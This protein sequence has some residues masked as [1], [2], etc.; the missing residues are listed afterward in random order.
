MAHISVNGPASGIDLGAAVKLTIQSVCRYDLKKKRIIGVEWKQKDEREQGPAS[1]AAAVETTTTLTRHLLDDEPVELTEY[2]LADADVDA[3]PAP[4]TEEMLQLSYTDPKDRFTLVY[5]REWQIVAQTDEHLTMRLMERGDFVA[6]VT[7]TPWDKAAPG[8]HMSGAELQE[9]MDNLPDWTP[10]QK[11]EDGE[12]PADQKD[13]WMYRISALGDLEGLKVMENY[14]VVAGPQ[15]DQ[16]ILAFTLRQGVVD[17]LG[18]RDM[19]LA[20][21]IGFKTKAEEK[22]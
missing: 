21:G 18:T 19:Q 12:V 14:F 4:P 15:G 2:A 17:K 6:Q 5:N 9:E 8:K 20:N 22:K 3:V 7:L 10:D 13:H 1:P 11:R 16:V